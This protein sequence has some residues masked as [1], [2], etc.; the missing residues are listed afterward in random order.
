[1]SNALSYFYGGE[2]VS[3]LS[4]ELELK[5][6]PNGEDSCENPLLSPAAF[7]HEAM[8]STRNLLALSTVARLILD[9][10][11]R[12]VK[13]KRCAAT[14]DSREL[15]REDAQAQPLQEDAQEQF[16]SRMCH[17]HKPEDDHAHLHYRIRELQASL[18]RIEISD[19]PD[20]TKD[21][22]R[23]RIHEQIELLH[24]RNNAAYGMSM[25]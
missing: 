22:V 1:M 20:M 18:K 24:Q 12:D 5:C 25:E 7:L 11:R 10:E 23:T 4:A 15:H 19:L 3:R 13:A 9:R 16:F 6:A 2:R 17:E 14:E 8:Q 21:I